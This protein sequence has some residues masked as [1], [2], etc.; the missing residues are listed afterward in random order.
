MRTKILAD[1]VLGDNVCALFAVFS[2]AYLNMDRF[3]PT[4]GSMSTAP[5][6]AVK[7]NLKHKPCTS[8]HCLVYTIFGKCSV[9]QKQDKFA[10]YKKA[11]AKIAAQKRPFIPKRVDPI[12]PHR[13][14]PIVLILV[15]T[16][17]IVYNA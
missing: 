4:M 7:E 17:C 11:Q 13:A 12:A 14:R 9:C 2:L 15:A 5:L 6:D 16:S 3:Y 10:L 8:K 1:S